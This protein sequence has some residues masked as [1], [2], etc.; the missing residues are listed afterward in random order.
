MERKGSP[1]YRRKVNVFYMECTVKSITPHFT[2]RQVINFINEVDLSKKV[3][4]S[5]NMGQYE[6]I[7]GDIQ[8]Y[9]I[10]ITDYKW[11]NRNLCVYISKPQ[12]C[13]L[14]LLTTFF[15]CK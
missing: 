1:T 7:A 3:E 6:R 8:K 15:K 5:F 12:E 11:Q 9:K 14:E 2:E 4:V 10:S 13:T